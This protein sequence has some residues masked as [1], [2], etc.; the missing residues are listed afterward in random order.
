MSKPKSTGKN[1]CA[2]KVHE[3]EEPKTRSEQISA[4][5]DQR[6]GSREKKNPKRGW[7]T[8]PEHCMLRRRD[9]EWWPRSEVKPEIGALLIRR[10]QCHH[11]RYF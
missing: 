5:S 11:V 1:A 9:I 2:T 6:S 10:T 3:E 7:G 8:G 4:T